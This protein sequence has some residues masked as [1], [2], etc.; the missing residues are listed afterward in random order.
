M[1]TSTNKIPSL[2]V[3]ESSSHWKFHITAINACKEG[4]PCHA[5][6]KYWSDMMFYF[7][8]DLIFYPLRSIINSSFMWSCCILISSMVLQTWLFCLLLLFLEYK[9][10]CQCCLTVSNYGYQLTY[11]CTP[12]PFYLLGKE[13]T[14][15]EYTLLWTKVFVSSVVRFYM[16]E[17]DA[18]LD[19]H[20]HGV[21]SLGN[22]LAICW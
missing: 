11:I 2:D 21:P 10:F 17:N 1:T 8:L 16:I 7:H 15:I 22:K 4:H 19:D 13:E 9:L 3:H 6:H 18:R 5:S 14:D 20:L 12:R